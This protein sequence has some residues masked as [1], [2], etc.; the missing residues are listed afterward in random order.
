MPSADITAFVNAALS[1][2]AQSKA[3]ADFARKKLH[4]A[5]QI[6]KRAL[7]R[8]PAHKTWVDRRPEAPLESVRPDGLIVFEF[9][10]QTELL[11]WIAEQLEKHSPR[12]RTGAFVRSHRLYADG[13]ETDPKKPVLAEEYVFL[14]SDKP[15]KVRALEGDP[16]TGNTPHSRQ[17]PNGVYEAVATLAH[18]RFNN[19]ASI[20]FTYRA[21]FQFS[22]RGLVGKERRDAE[23]DARVPA[24]VVVAR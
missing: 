11:G 9:Q 17:A 14:S 23:K 3:V 5:Q 2:Q 6:N 4:E 20:F 19:Q 24:I 21:P 8:V 22:A 7:G 13:V 12:G 10:L 15:G 1:P 16:R 18:K